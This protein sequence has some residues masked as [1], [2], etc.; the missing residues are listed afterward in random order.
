M[1]SFLLACA[2]AIMLAQMPSSAQPQSLPTPDQP[3][4]MWPDGAPGALGKTANDIPTLTAY[5]APPELATGAAIVIC[6]GGGYAGLAPHEGADYAR[7]LNEQG[8]TGFVLKYRLGSHG[9]RHPRMLED[10]ARAVR[11]VR[12]HAGDWGIDPKR[13]GIMGSSAGGHLA[14]TLLTHFDAGNPDAPDP[15]DRVSCRPDIG[16]LC[17]AVITM[18]HYTH[19]GSKENLLGKDP[20]PELIHELSNEL[21]VTKDTPQCFIFH[22]AEDAAVPVENSLM[23]AAALRQAGVLFDLHIYEH[24]GHGMGLGSKTWDPSHWH[25]WTRDCRFWL[26]EQGFAK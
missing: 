18:G 5:F 26:K 8:I 22:T 4:V 1:K 9:Y 20:T 17:Y 12:F 23:F 6:P 25:P 21:H 24:G 16:I 19:R 15:I 10:A 14:S 13:I 3:I 7:W 11:I 2:A